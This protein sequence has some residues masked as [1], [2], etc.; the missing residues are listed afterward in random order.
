VSGANVR[1]VVLYTLVELCGEKQK[2]FIN[3][4]VKGD[5]SAVLFTSSVTVKSFFECTE[6]LGVER[7]LLDS[8]RRCLIA[9]IG[10]PTTETLERYEIHV[11]IMPPKA[12][13]VDLV[14]AVDKALKAQSYSEKFPAR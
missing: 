13:Y 6:A 9:S 3:A 10:K 4:I 5:V 7:P 14:A 11:D 1:E 2:H 8:L 12:T